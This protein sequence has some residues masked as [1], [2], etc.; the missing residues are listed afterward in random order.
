[1]WDIE[2]LFSWD[3]RT[4]KDYRNDIK[5]TEVLRNGKIHKRCKKALKTKGRLNRLRLPVPA[6]CPVCLRRLPCW[7]TARVVH[8]TRDLVLTYIRDAMS[9]NQESEEELSKDKNPLAETG[10]HQLILKI[11][12]SPFVPLLTWQYIVYAHRKG[13][14]SRC[15]GFDAYSSSQTM[16]EFR[17]QDTIVE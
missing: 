12:A 4:F 17:S 16:E 2:I 13:E 3:H 7:R 6:L 10:S 11:P 8:F 14:K 1:M 5:R 15:T 9:L